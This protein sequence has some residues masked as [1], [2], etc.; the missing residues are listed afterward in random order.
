MGR[1]LLDG[2][3][4]SPTLDSPALVEITDSNSLSLFQPK[5]GPS[6]ARIFGP[7]FVSWL[8]HFF[9][10]HVKMGRQCPVLERGFRRKGELWR[11]ASANQATL[12]T[13]QQWQSSSRWSPNS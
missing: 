4:D 11:I 13:K 8:R 10:S 2:G 9:L 12:K 6:I 3:L 5:F 7:A 1:S